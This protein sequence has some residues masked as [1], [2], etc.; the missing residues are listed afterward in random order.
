MDAVRHL[1]FEPLSFGRHTQGPGGTIKV[2]GRIHYGVLST[3]S[4]RQFRRIN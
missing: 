2:G 3:W 1:N 4:A